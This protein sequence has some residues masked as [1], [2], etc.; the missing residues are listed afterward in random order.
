MTNL[1]KIFI[2]IVILLGISTPVKT[3]DSTKK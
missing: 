1:I 3:G 2:I